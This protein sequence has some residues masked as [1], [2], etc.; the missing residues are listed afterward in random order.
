[1]TSNWGIKRSH[2][3]T[4]YIYIYIIYLFKEKIHPFWPGKRSLKHQEKSFLI[5]KH[6]QTHEIHCRLFR[7]PCNFQTTVFQCEDFYTKFAQQKPFR[8]DLSGFVSWNPFF[9]QKYCSSTLFDS[10]SVQTTLSKHLH[11]NLIFPSNFLT[12][13][14]RFWEKFRRNIFP[15]KVCVSGG[16]GIGFFLMV[17]SGVGGYLGQTKTDE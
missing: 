17:F 1:M 5:M 7:E 13:E 3:I 8:E 16:V 12:W 2:W 14:A 11:N 6:F 10:Q 9:C 15:V 4:W